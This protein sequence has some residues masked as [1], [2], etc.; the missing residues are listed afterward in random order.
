MSSILELMS[1]EKMLARCLK[2]LQRFLP[3]CTQVDAVVAPRRIHRSGQIICLTHL[4]YYTI[5]PV[6]TG[7]VP[8]VEK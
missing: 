8:R 3:P 1:P 7:F 2:I 5:D 6:K 4:L